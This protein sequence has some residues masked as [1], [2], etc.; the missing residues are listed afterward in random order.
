MASKSPILEDQ[1]PVIQA[2]LY[3][4]LSYSGLFKT[5]EREEVITVCIADVVLII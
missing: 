2:M 4:L 5:H 1:S 3:L